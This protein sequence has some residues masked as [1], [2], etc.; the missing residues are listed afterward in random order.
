MR[1]G[2]ALSGDNCAIIAA[3]LNRSRGGE[4]SIYWQMSMSLNDG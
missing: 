1:M 3:M 2:A 4:G